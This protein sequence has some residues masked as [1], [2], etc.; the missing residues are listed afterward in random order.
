MRKA[1]IIF[2]MQK[3]IFGKW[4]SLCRVTEVRSCYPN[5]ILK[6]KKMHCSAA[7]LFAKYD[8][9]PEIE[10]RILIMGGDS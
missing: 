7:G 5:L 8:V 10:K 1:G 2:H 3:V 4:R 9:L 6:R